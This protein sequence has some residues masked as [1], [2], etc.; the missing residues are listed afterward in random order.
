VVWT[1]PDL[2][3]GENAS[4]PTH[5]SLVVVGGPNGAGKTTLALG[6]ATDLGC[7]YLGADQ[8]AS[9]H[10]L[11]RTGAD[12]VRAG[13][14]F[15]TAVAG[16]LARRDSLL[17]E[18][19][20]SGLSTRRLLEE[21]K[22]AGYDVSVVF[23]FVESAEV[24]LARIRARVEKGGH[25][26]PDEDVRRRFGRS[27]RNFWDVYRHLADRWQLQYNG[28]GGLARVAQGRGD[29]VEVLDA[30]RLQTFGSLMEMR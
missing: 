22:V 24:C 23:V 9:D 30:V 27:L 1:C 5:P 14:L 12:A 20:L 18:S 10:G 16:R 29:R 7:T 25:S 15:R 8:V 3:I 13:R 6:L 19:T 11:G 2:A 28:G 21:F 4:V 17:L 26:V